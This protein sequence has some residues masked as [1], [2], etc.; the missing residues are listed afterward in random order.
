[1]SAPACLPV[2]IVVVLT[3][4][5][6]DAAQYDALI[7]AA[8]TL[9]AQAQ[10][11]T[12]PKVEVLR[13]LAGGPATAPAL[14]A[15]SVWWEATHG[16]LTPDASAPACAAVIQQAL[17]QMEIEAGSRAI[18]LLPAG[19]AGVEIAAL[20]ADHFGGSTLG[21]CQALAIRDD[22]VRADKPAFGGRAV[23]Q[24]RANRWPCFA[25]L[26]PGQKS[27]AMPLSVPGALRRIDSDCALPQAW[28]TET[29]ASADAQRAL[30]GA[31]MVVS[32]GRGMRSPEG[33]ALLEALARR[34]DAALAGSL[35]AVDAGWVPVARQVGQSGKFVA[36]RSYIAVGISGTPQHLA[37]V[38]T[39]T[40]I[41][42]VNSD[43]L[44]PI[45]QVAEIGVIA[46]W[47]E[48]LPRLLE[49]LQARQGE[50]RGPTPTGC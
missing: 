47:Q 18:V 36:P 26:R 6:D 4:T 8:Q 22:T 30:V 32:G 1:M 45:F 41:I 20:L 40:S 31:R 17:H 34:L 3:G 25:A 28:P 42:A 48:L 21:R 37:G 12:V 27:S 9:S 33:F 24:M 16:G 29:L 2:R 39:E 15:A 35:P 10:P 7:G 38:S 14:H 44:A 23:A 49:R 46:D 11:D 13:L 50:T 5:L 43:P 19:P